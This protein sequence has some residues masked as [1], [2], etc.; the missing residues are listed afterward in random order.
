MGAMNAQLVRTSG[1]GAQFQQRL[2]MFAFYHALEGYSLLAVLE[3]DF[4]PGTVVK[5]R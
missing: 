5:V 2:S 3:V 1:Q 4:L